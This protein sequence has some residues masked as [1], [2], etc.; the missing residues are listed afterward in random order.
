MQVINASILA[1]FWSSLAV[2]SVAAY[3][4]VLIYPTAD[5]VYSPSQYIAGFSD[6]ANDTLDIEVNGAIVAQTQTNATGDFALSVTLSEGENL[7]RVRSTTSAEVSDTQALKYLNTG[8]SDNTDG[9]LEVRTDIVAPVLNL[10]NT[11][12]LINPITLTGTAEPGSTVSF[13]VNGRVIRNIDADDSGVFST[14]VPLEDG[15]NSI[16]AIAEI[17]IGQSIASNSVT[18]TYT[19]TL[20]R[21]WSGNVSNTLVWTKGDG[22]PYVLNDDLNVL[23]GATL[24]IQPGVEVVVDGNHKLTAFG[25][26]QVAGLGEE[27]VKFKPTT[28]SCNGTNTKRLDWGGIQ[29]RPAASVTLSHTEIHCAAKGVHFNGGGGSVRNSYFLNNY[30]GIRTEATSEEARISPQITGSAIRG[31]YYGIYV[32]HN[33]DPYISA[34]NVIT[35]NTHGIYAYGNSG[36]AAQNPAPLVTG[37]SLYGNSSYNY[38]TQYFAN[39]SS[40]TLD[41]TGNWWGTTD[42]SQIKAKIYDWTDSPTYNPV[43]DYRNFLDGP[44]GEPAYTGEALLGSIAEDITLSGDSLLVLGRVEIAA[45]TVLTIAAGTELKFGGK[46]PLL[47]RGELAVNGRA[48]A[49]VLFRPVAEACNGINTRRQ[50]WSGIEVVAGATAAIE[51]AQVH[52]AVNGIHFNRGDGSV[53]N[54]EFLNNYT[55]IRT[56]ATSV[57]ARISPHIAGSAIRGSYYGIYVSHNSDPQISNGNVISGNEYGIYAYG[58]S[59]DAAQNPAPVVT[60][61]SLYDNSSYN[62]YTQYF[63]NWSS[64]TLDATGN[65]WGKTDPS[66]IAA[67]IYDWTDSNYLPI[68]DYRQFLDSPEG[69]P[70]YK[71]EALLG[72]FTEDTVLLE[73]SYLIL[74]RVEVAAGTTLSIGAGT[75]LQFAGYFP[76]RVQGALSA[77]GSSASP[78]VFKSTDQACDGNNT[79]RRD[80]PGIEV[81]AGATANI[82]YAEVHCA[83]IG[84]QFNGGDGSVRNSELLNNYTGIKTIAASAEARIA[85]KIT[86]NKIS[87]SREGIDVY[88]NSDPQITAGNVITGNQWGINADGH[89]TDAAQNPVPVVTGNSLYDNSSYNY[90]I[91]YYVDGASTTLD[92]TGNW[93]GS[94]ELELIVESIFDFNDQPYLPLV[95]YSGYLDGENG[96]LAHD[97]VTLFGSIA[98]DTVLSA[99]DYLMLQSL[100]VEPGITLTIEAGA[101][102]KSAPDL[103]LQV[104][105][106]L[107]VQGTVESRVDFAPLS[108]QTTPG[109]WYGI[110]VVAGGSVDL[111]YARV[112]GAEYGLDFNGGQGTVRNSLFRFNTYGIYVRAGSNPLI[113]DGNEITFNDY[114]IYIDG[115]GNAVNNPRPVITGNSLYSNNHYDLYATNFGEPTNVNL[116]VSDN[117][118]GT[119]DEVAIQTQIYAD[120][121]SSPQVNF[122]GYRDSAT[123]LPAVRLSD[124]ALQVVKFHPLEGERAQGSFSLNRPANV[125]IEIHR[126]SDDKLVYLASESYVEAGVYPISWDGRDNQNELQAEGLYRVVLRAND[127]LDDFIYDLPKPNGEGYVQGTVPALYDVYANELYKVLVQLRTPGLV[128]MQVTPSGESAFS[129]FEDVF[130]P[131]GNHWLYWNGRDPEGHIVESSAAIYYPTPKL[132]RSTA[133]YLAGIAPRITGAVAAPS[134]EVKSDPYRVSH[135]YEQLTRMAYQVSTDAVVTFSL[136]P[137]GVV[138]PDHPS[139]IVL[140]DERLMRAKDGEDNA[141]LHE[142]EWR[143]YNESDPNA[144]LVGDEGAYTFAIQ[145]TSPES[146]ESTLY[147]G[148]VNLYR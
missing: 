94:T 138:D 55:G 30:Y 122:S 114:G 24:W 4:E 57:E 69:E 44:E 10:P 3:A 116:D 85:P 28:N 49:P 144:V 108:I 120:D 70:V 31:S 63:A 99:D 36:D 54:S 109:E 61:N 106:T 27:L 56:K 136:L 82:E 135:S 112:E 130:Y 74:G 133:I 46:Y 95:N 5:R 12:G 18:T 145:A 126:D 128:S 64:T 102:L 32:S 9:Q 143:G 15:D 84:I 40:T 75:E 17:D 146:G 148:V 147:R 105:G 38:Y 132:V 115:G 90:H 140:V 119:A 8:D 11:D 7:I 45:N 103:K 47:V 16:Y 123:D 118:W 96:Q 29:I 22:S 35:E 101:N 33:S 86:G 87:G 59:G 77:Q 89:N 98:E 142:V 58:N 141:L 41:A 67:K 68:I 93:W 111:N 78:I 60:G 76:L 66:Q 42:P 127:G 52:C 23:A 65:W 131:Q 97:A 81:I 107:L 71:G 104:A 14:W 62:Y 110:E 50:D 1:V 129:V 125:T 91:L 39:S 73:D 134:I 88:I 83:V 137:P 13:F 80:W 21:D 25:H 37:N 92:A 53:R 6:Q 48:E 139:A 124:V 19:N 79:Q 72:Y 117:W 100:R 2:F 113:T 121:S 20:V 43:V 34:G 51:Y 26:L